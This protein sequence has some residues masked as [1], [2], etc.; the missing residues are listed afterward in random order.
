ML[1]VG[2]LTLHLF[3]GPLGVNQFQIGLFI[4]LAVT[5]TVE[6]SAGFN[7]QLIA[8]KGSG[9]LSIRHNLDQIGATFSLEAAA[10]D[11][12]IGIYFAIDVS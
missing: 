8:V 4:R 10:D 9:K 12:L 6:V 2:D 5:V 1:F 11:Q 3:F 7:H